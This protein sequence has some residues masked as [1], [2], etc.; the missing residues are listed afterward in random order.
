[1]LKNGFLGGLGFGLAIST[2]HIVIGVAL[3]LALGMP[4]L[5]AFAFNALVIEIVCGVVAGVL[6]SPLTRLPKGRLLHVAVLAAIWLGLERW[7]AVDPTKLQMWIGP[8][9]GALVLF[10]I[11]AR[12]RKRWPRVFYTLAVLIPAIVPFVPEIKH[13]VQGGYEI[14]PPADRPKAPE[15]A[16][17][18]LFIVMDTVRAQSVSAYGY[19]RKTTPNFDTLAK[20]GLFI[21]DATSPATWSLP[22]HASLFTGALPSVSGAHEESRFLYEGIPTIAETMASLGWE[23]RAFSANPH[24]SESFGLTRG[25]DWT[26]QAW[27]TGAGG[28]GFTFIYRL[29]DA[30]GFSAQDKGGGQVVKNIQD[31]MGSRPK[32]APPAFVFVNFLEAH[33]PFHQLPDDQ[34]Y[35]YTKEDISELRAVGQIAFGVQFGRQLTDAEYTR[36]HQ[37]IKDMYDGGVHYTDFLMGEVVEEWRKRGLLDNTIVIVLGDHGE[38]TGEHGAFGHVTPLYEEVLR[39]PLMFRYPA[40]ITAGSRVDMPVSSAATFATVMDLLGQPKPERSQY[41]SLLPG[42][43]GA[44]VGQ[45]VVAERFEEHMLSARFEPGTANGHGLLLSPFGRYRT[46]RSGNYKLG[47]YSDGSVYLFD[48]AADPG[49]MTDVASTQTGEKDRL[50]NELSVI[51]DSYGLVGLDAELPKGPSTVELSDAAQEQLRA[52]GY[53]E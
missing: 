46:F 19:E 53:I 42:A 5:T 43:T 31:W 16:P 44:I 17:D 25:F 8:T 13:R 41:S 47:K 39:V 28:R 3:I 22:A 52:L 50:L 21:A 36:I 45:P 40:K 9:V 37:P 51:E 12:L 4:P 33:F 14:K 1:M 29:I 27:I 18:V 24:I 20:E 35:L 38:T 26:D 10:V 11:G 7:V 49:E 32:D 2:V 6:L 48:L 30:M 15:G 23:T 34:L